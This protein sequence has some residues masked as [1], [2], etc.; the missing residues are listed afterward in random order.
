MQSSGIDR[1]S[2]ARRLAAYGV[3]FLLA[4]GCSSFQRHWKEAAQAE[5]SSGGLAGAWDVTWTS[6]ASGH[7]GRLRC[8][9][10]AQDGTNYQAWFRANYAKVFNFG[11]KVTLRALPAQDRQVFHGE[12]NLGALVGGVYTYD[13]YATATNLYSSYR[14]RMD[15]GRFEM[16]RPSLE[17]TA[18][19]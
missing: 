5:T 3:V 17:P 14:C 4:T 12:A 11:Y 10:R 19:R 7:Q 9:I 1:W 6:E 15:H 8:L 16:R 13:G 2:F 18:K